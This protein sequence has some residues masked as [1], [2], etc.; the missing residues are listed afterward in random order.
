MEEKKSI[1][2][3]RE[4]YLKEYNRLTKSITDLELELRELQTKYLETCEYKVGDKVKL[5]LTQ[6]SLDSDLPD[7]EVVA[8]IINI[9]F[10]K[11]LKWH[12]DI[13]VEFSYPK[14]NREMST[15]N[16]HISMTQIKNIEKVNE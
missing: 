9:G 6:F 1:D 14:K 5:T 16:A 13:E 2:K 4:N 8:H 11:G 12:R 15:K 7:K 10:G 3:R